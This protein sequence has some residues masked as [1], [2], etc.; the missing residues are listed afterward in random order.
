ML[1]VKTKFANRR[2]LALV[3]IYAAFAAAAFF[4]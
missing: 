3:V 2:A 1:I 4:A